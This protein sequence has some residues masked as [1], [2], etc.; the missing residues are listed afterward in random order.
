MLMIPFIFL[1]LNN[2][3]AHDRSAF[4]I[5][6]VDFL[7]FFHKKHGG[8]L[9]KVPWNYQSGLTH[10]S[11]SETDFT[12]LKMLQAARKLILTGYYRITLYT[13]H[14]RTIL[15]WITPL[16]IVTWAFWILLQYLPS[17]LFWYFHP[18][19]RTFFCS[20]MLSQPFF[21]SHIF[22]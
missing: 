10:I 6:L 20:P 13:H 3:R 14:T 5:H 16:S 22:F 9:I 18:M 19:T 2:N 12:H 17:P 7:E 15:C 1:R 11:Q 4:T 21:C 8:Q